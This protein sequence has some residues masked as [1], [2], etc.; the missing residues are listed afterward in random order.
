MLLLFKVKIYLTILLSVQ[1]ISANTV[2]DVAIP[3]S[4]MENTLETG[5]S[6]IAVKKEYMGSVNRGDIMLFYCSADD[7]SV[8]IKRVI[9]LPEEHIEIKNGKIYVDYSKHEIQER[10]LKEEWVTDNDGYMFDVPPNCYLMLGDNRNNSYDA[11]YWG[12][13]DTPY[14]NENDILGKAIFQYSPQIKK[15]Y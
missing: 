8:Y 12:N 13:I 6:L 10:Y 14:V 4:S 7:N 11:R 1:S 3:T 5:S 2:L 9:G 15:L